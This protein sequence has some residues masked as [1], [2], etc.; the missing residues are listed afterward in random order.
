MP[1]ILFCVALMLAV[2]ANM[3]RVIDQEGMYIAVSVV[4]HHFS[5]HLQGET[6]SNDTVSSRTK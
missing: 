3:L 6:N 5:V 4:T 2:K 1:F